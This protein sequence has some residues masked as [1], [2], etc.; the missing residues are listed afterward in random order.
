MRVQ[1]SRSSYLVLVSSS[2]VFVTFRILQWRA[3][4]R[5]RKTV[6]RVKEMVEE[7]QPL[8]SKRVRCKDYKRLYMDIHSLLLRVL[9]LCTGI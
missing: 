5:A 1:V 9:R 8:V 4:S 2:A 3:R 6:E 7:N